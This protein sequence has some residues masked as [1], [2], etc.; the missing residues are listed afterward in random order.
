MRYV[1][2]IPG[3]VV[4]LAIITAVDVTLP[5]GQP[6]GDVNIIL[7][8]STFLFA[9]LVGFFIARLAARYD[10]IRSN[11][12]QED[13]QM[14][15]VYR[16]ARLIN[17]KL[18]ARMATQ[19]DT[20]YIAA[21]DFSLSN[22]NAA[23]KATIDPFRALWDLADEIDQQKYSAAFQMLVQQLTMIEQSRNQASALSQ[24][25][26]RVGSWVL[27][28]VLAAII[29]VSVFYVRTEALYSHV[30]TIGLS[31]ALVMI[32]LIL[33]DLQNMMLGG[34]SLLEESGQEVLEAIGKKR[35]YH[36]VYLNAG[37]SHV[38][39]TA[40][41]YRVGSHAP[42]SPKHKIKLVKR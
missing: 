20:Y 12:A 4:G 33:R 10:G 25:K 17:K 30:V 31:T 32:L 1:H 21:Y 27:M 7:T 35:Y 16:T 36:E 13:A 41:E 19:M 18:A 2:A 15:A 40:K 34:Q 37:I 6:S 28:L 22:A 38:P 39:K 8:I 14:L 9:I 3:T 29:L 42:G 23:Y 5:N 11:I 26:M 24:E